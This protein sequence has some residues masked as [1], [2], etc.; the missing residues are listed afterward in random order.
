MTMKKMISLAG[1]E[2]NARVRTVGKR[3]CPSHGSLH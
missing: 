3:I 2:R 1:A